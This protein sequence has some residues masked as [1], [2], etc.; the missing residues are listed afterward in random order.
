MLKNHP[1]EDIYPV[2]IENLDLKPRTVYDYQLFLKR[3]IHYLKR[4]NIKY[5]KRK[6][7]IK[8]KQVMIEERLAVTTIRKQITIIKG[9]YKW[10][11]FSYKE[12]G[13]DEQYQIDIAESVRNENLNRAFRKDPLTLEEAQLLIQTAKDKADTLIGL[14]NYCIVLLM[15]TTGLRIIE[16]SRA[17]RTDLKRWRGYDVLYIQGKGRLRT[18]D[19]VKLPKEVIRLLEEY[20]FLRNDRN[21]FVFSSNHTILHNNQLSPD[22]IRYQLTKLLNDTGLKSK[23]ITIHSLRHTCAVLNLET[24]G[25]IEQTRQLLR[26][27]SIETTMIYSHNLTKLHDESSQRIS[28]NILMGVKEDDQEYK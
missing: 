11:R 20:F 15:I 19:F 9:F 26:H 24:G 5:A 8:Y 27:Q 16:V 10:L 28:K 18:D 6:D 13:F 23:R 25:T 12:Y 21:P 3:Y 14:R 4:Y 17:K 22:A 1:L 2:Y 7:L